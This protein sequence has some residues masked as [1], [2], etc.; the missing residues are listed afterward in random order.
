MPVTL[1][2]H[3]KLSVCGRRRTVIEE[4]LEMLYDA[5]YEELEHFE[6]EKKSSLER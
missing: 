1:L 5:Y 6:K 4:E 2:A 3:S